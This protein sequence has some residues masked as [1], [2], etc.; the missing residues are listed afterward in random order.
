MN[1]LQLQ[2][3]PPFLNHRHLGLCSCGS[4]AVTPER[5][6]PGDPAPEM[7]WFLLP[8]C[9]VPPLSSPAVERTGDDTIQPP[10]QGHG[11]D[12]GI[13]FMSQ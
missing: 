6:I 9:A 2:P 3:M 5:G 11:I 1:L 7:D 10:A 4:Q 8:A 13:W 12:A